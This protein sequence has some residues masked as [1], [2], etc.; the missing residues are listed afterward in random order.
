MPIDFSAPRTPIYARDPASQ[1]FLLNG[2]MEGHV[3]VKNVNKTLPL[4]QPKLISIFGYDAFAPAT[5]DPGLAI[6]LYADGYEPQLAFEAFISSG[7][8]PPT[9]LN[10]TMIS[11]GENHLPSLIFPIDRFTNIYDYCR[12]KW[13]QCPSLYLSTL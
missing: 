10:G 12:R 1:P 7:P 6:G 11:G 2:A 13:C 8:A 5:V 3:L 4:S 9:A